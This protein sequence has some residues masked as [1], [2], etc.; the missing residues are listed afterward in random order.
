MN[1]IIITC[2]SCKKEYSFIL[3]TSQWLDI[4][5]GKKVQDVLPKL[6]VDERELFISK[7]CGTCFGRMFAEG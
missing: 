7:I 5:R 3:T 4:K 6:S 2:K 1:Q